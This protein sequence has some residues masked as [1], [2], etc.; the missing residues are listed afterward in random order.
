M[1]MNTLI[2]KII[3]AVV[4]IVSLSFIS[5]AWRNKKDSDKPK[6]SPLVSTNYEKLQYQSQ[7]NP[8]GPSDFRQ[9][10]SQSESQP[11]PESESA[12]VVNPLDE[13][14]SRITKKPF[15][16]YVSPESS[17]VSPEK[18]KGYHTG[19]DLE[20]RSEELDVD[21]PVKVL[22]DG[23]L[24]S[25]RTA[26]G[27]GG[28]AVQSCNLDGQDVTVIY[29]HIRLS[30]LNAKVGDRLEA[31]QYLANLGNAYSEE[32]D[33]ERKHLHLGIY[34]GNDI[35]ILGYVQ[36]QDELSSWIDPIKFLK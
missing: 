32:T 28:M 1:L 21:V 11:V 31:G 27:Y 23:Q 12:N 24:L 20:V 25:T 6:R 3:I 9:D 7:P 16:V 18:F 35:N 19:A 29:G 5:V 33:D 15:G 17:P 34:R 10:P 2:R 13:P 22:C 8:E 30:S 4:V 36:S 26:T 14:L